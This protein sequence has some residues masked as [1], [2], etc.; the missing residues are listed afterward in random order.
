MAAG[1]PATVD[2]GIKAL[3]DGGSLECKLGTEVCCV[4]STAP[5]FCV[6]NN[7]SCAS[8]AGTAR[9]YACVTQSHCPEGKVCCALNDES[10]S[11]VSSVACLSAGECIE[12]H[13]PACAN[14]SECSS[15]STCV[16]YDSQLSVCR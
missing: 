3:E 16:P 14:Q 13:A 12:P 15:G 10:G 1:H 5:N 8:A 4:I 11:F 6:N 7:E 9:P 2:A